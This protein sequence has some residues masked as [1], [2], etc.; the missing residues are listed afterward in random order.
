MN[1]TIDAQGKKLGRVASEAATL[2]MGKNTPEYARNIAPKVKVHITNVSK[3]NIDAKKRSSSIYREFTGFRGGL[4]EIS[5]DKII[6]EK[7]FGEL[8]KR[9]VYGMLPHNSLNKEMMKNLIITE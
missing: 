2:L 8:F 5:M 4:N 6:K 1:Y 9:A 7:G 3:A